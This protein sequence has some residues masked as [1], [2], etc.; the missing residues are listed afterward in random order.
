LGLLPRVF[1]RNT[2]DDKV[3]TINSV[4]AVSYRAIDKWKNTPEE[5]PITNWTNLFDKVWVIHITDPKATLLFPES[6]SVICLQFEDAV[7]N[8]GKNKNTPKKKKNKRKE[9]FVSLS[10]EDEDDDQTVSVMFSKEKLFTDEDAE[11]IVSFISEAHKNLKSN[12]ALLVNCMA[13]V[14]R[15]G[16]VVDFARVMCSTS[17]DEFKRLNPLVIPNVHVKQLL[18]SNWFADKDSLYDEKEEN[19]SSDDMEEI[20]VDD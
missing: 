7:P 3:M 13:G 11:K 12:D 10:P 17:Y 9:K 1:Q 20:D 6:D 16:A 19:D 2:K 5:S 4:R 8:Y 14:S 15:S 18:F